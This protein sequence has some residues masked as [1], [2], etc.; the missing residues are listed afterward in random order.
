MPGEIRREVVRR[1][2]ERNGI[3]FAEAKKLFKSKP[4]SERQ[5]VCAE[6]HRKRQKE[7]EKNG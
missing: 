6:I 2:A 1:I 7:A 5:R 4:A 3:S